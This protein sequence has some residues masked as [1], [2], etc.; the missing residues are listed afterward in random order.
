[1]KSENILWYIITY[2]FV[3]MYEQ[4]E[5]IFYVYIYPLYTGLPVANGWNPKYVKARA[6]LNLVWNPSSPIDIPYSDFLHM[7]NNYLRRH[8]F[9]ITKSGQLRRIA[10][11]QMYY[12]NPEEALKWGD[13]AWKCHLKNIEDNFEDYKKE[14]TL[15]PF[16]CVLYADHISLFGHDILSYNIQS[17]TFL[18]QKYE[19]DAIDALL[20]IIFILCTIIMYIVFYHLKKLT[21]KVKIL[22][23]FIITG[24]NEEEYDHD[25]RTLKDM[26]KEER[27]IIL[28]KRRFAKERIK[29][30]NDNISAKEMNDAWSEAST[31]SPKFY[32]GLEIDYCFYEFSCISLE[33]SIIM[34]L[35]L[36][37]NK[38]YALLHYYIY[39][40]YIMNMEFFTYVF[41]Y[42]FGLLSIF[43]WFK[44]KNDIRK[45]THRWV[46]RDYYFSHFLNHFF[47]TLC[48]LN[49]YKLV[50]DVDIFWY[51]FFYSLAMIWVYFGCDSCDYFMGWNQDYRIDIYNNQTKFH[52][53]WPRELMNQTWHHFYI[54][55]MKPIHTILLYI[56]LFITLP[57]VGIF[58][59]WVYY[60]NKIHVY[61]NNKFFFW[62]SKK[63]TID[64]IKNQWN[65]DRV[66]NYIK[67]EEAKN[68]R[69]KKITFS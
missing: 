15:D 52:M 51:V 50:Y 22:Q 25:A 13:L 43:F 32:I 64:E 27:E 68:N 56:I 65:K 7:D 26:K 37:F 62:N 46:E 18:F 41:V 55:L 2:P 58:L 49:L 45:A 1:M 60:Q 47:R 3:W 8:G 36:L 35:Y 44:L 61:I 54:T 48:W 10:S 31:T 39:M 38:I 11:P 20:S 12:A 16:E 28:A 14:L 67:E 69:E 59:K 23:H 9:E 57:F 33:L 4:L 63:Y 19:I 21:F 34:S 53:W 30:Y 6:K 42:L 29:Q 40:F 5:Y 24:M 17:K 66:I